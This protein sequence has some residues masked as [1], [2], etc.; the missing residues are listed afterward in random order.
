MRL[1]RL[2]RLIRGWLGTTTYGWYVDDG[3]I[4]AYFKRR[5]RR[6]VEHRTGFSANDPNVYG[7][8]RWSGVAERNEVCIR[9]WEV[10]YQ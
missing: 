4:V 1:L 2:L 7:F 9:E 5:F 6:R 10:D 8:V 3:E